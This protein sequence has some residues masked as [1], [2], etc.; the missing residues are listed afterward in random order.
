[1]LPGLSSKGV[2]KQIDIEEIRAEERNHGKMRASCVLL[3]F[4]PRRTVDWFPCFLESLIE[5]ELDDIAE[6]LDPDRFKGRLLL[7]ILNDTT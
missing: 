4:L 7:L 2:F 6:M 1:M 5:C 3:M